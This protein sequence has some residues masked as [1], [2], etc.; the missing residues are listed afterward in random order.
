MKYFDEQD[1][2]IHNDYRCGIGKKLR[3]QKK[4]KRKIQ[5]QSRKQRK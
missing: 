2:G 3:K 5:K 4:A 1:Y